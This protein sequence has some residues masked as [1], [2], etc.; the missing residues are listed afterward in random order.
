VLKVALKVCEKRLRELDDLIDDPMA[1]DSLVTDDEWKVL[2]ADEL[3]IETLAQKK[4]EDWMNK[5]DANMK[6]KKEQEML[7]EK[8]EKK[9]KDKKAK[10][11]KKKAKKVKNPTSTDPVEN[12]ENY[13]ETYE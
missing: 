13:S 5:N 4:H 8:L 1:F 10:K 6:K 9:K 12:N 7:L 3:N 11:L 2:G